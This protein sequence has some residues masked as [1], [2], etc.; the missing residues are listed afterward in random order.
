MST[1]TERLYAAWRSQ[2]GS[3]GGRLI[4]CVKRAPTPSHPQKEA[5]ARATNTPGAMTNIGVINAS[6]KNCRP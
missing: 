1:F 3:D 2:S 4:H 5:P 6:R